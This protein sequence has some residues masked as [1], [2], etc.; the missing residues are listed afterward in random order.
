[1]VPRAVYGSGTWAVRKQ[2]ETRIQKA[3]MKFLFGVAGCMHTDH[4]GKKLKG[5]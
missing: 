2:H 3:K 5:F 4:Q 1:M